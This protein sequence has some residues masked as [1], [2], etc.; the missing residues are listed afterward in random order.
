MRS[1]QA[2]ESKLSS[3]EREKILE[4]IEAAKKVRG[5]GGLEDLRGRLSDMEKAAAIIGQAM[6]RP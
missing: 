3:G 5:D 4:A 6:L 1:V 2:L